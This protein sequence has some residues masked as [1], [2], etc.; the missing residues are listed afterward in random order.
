M[1]FQGEGGVCHCVPARV[2]YMPSSTGCLH[3]PEYPGSCV[4]PGAVS[5][6]HSLLPHPLTLPACC[7][8]IVSPD[9]THSR[10]PSA[11]CLILCCLLFLSLFLL[12]FV[13]LLCFM[14][15]FAMLS[16]EAPRV[17]QKLQPAVFSIRPH[18][19][20]LQGFTVVCLLTYLCQR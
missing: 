11:R 8:H 18:R 2:L 19:F 1:P 7:Q 20:Q 17:C 13:S 15:L 14:H 12:W 3:L 5:R 16:R 9:L 10:P 4:S 6:Q